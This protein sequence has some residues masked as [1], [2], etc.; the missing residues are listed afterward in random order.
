MSSKRRKKSLCNAL[1]SFTKTTFTV[2]QTVVDIYDFE[3]RGDFELNWDQIRR[4]FSKINM[5]NYSFAGSIAF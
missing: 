2:A 5:Q 3:V 1:M 4:L